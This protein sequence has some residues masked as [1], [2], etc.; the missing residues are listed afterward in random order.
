[1]ADPVILPQVIAATVLAGWV[2]QDDAT[3]SRDY[4]GP[5]GVT[6]DGTELV[7][8]DAGQQSVATEDAGDVDMQDIFGTAEE[9]DLAPQDAPDPRP[10]L[11]LQMSEALDMRWRIVTSAYFDVHRVDEPGFG[12]NENRL[13]FY[14]AYTPNRHIQLVGDIEP[15]FMGVS[16]ARELNDLATRQMIAPFHVESDAAYLGLLDLLPGLDVKIG[17]QIVVW[18]TADKFN[19]TNNI[20]PDDLEDRPL[21]TEPI[22]N[23]MVVVDIAPWGDRLWLQGVYVPLFYPALLPPSAA[24]A[25]TDPRGPVPYA[26]NSD[27]VIIED[28]RDRM[29][30]EPALVPEVQGH[31]VMPKRAFGNGQAAAKLGARFWDID[32]SVSYYYGRHDIPT[33]VNVES[34]QLKS[35][36]SAQTPEDQLH[37]GCC[38]VSDAFLVYPKMQVLGADF[39]TQVPFL[40]N[41][42]VWGEMGVFFPEAQSFRIEFPI[43]IAIDGQLETELQGPTIRDTPFVKATAGVDYTFGRH[44]YVQAQYLRGFIDEFGV[45]HIGNY[46]VGGA[47]LL[48]FGRNLIF[49]LFGVVDIPTGN[50]DF[51]GNPD[52]GS[53]VIFPAVVAVPPWG[54]LT[55][56]AGGFF[57][58]GGNDTKFGQ[59]AAGSSVAFLKATGT[60]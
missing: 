35:V 55:F 10:A 6:S 54:F 45:D 21:F 47:D 26:R 19:P 56:E 16:Q 40:G 52:K 46:I 27:L 3:S 44:L 34:T 15:V 36:D 11:P 13:E 14:F 28:L 18:G 5:S 20:N 43:P 9:R 48:F 31:V 50:S 49:R 57:L 4:R 51:R 24:A 17:R 12:R 38:F 1:M 41:L 23:Q 37:A 29:D 39:V 2:A 33:P 60:F 53:F 8:I 32:V 58:F 7:P 42:G 30:I 25:L 22:A 59:S